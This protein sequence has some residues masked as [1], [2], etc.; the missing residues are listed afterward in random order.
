MTQLEYRKSIRDLRQ[1][2]KGRTYRAG[3]FRHFAIPNKRS[4][5]WYGIWNCLSQNVVAF[6]NVNK[7]V[8]RVRRNSAY[9][10]GLSNIEGWKVVASDTLRRYRDRGQRENTE[11]YA[12]YVTE[13]QLLKF[14][15]A[16]TGDELEIDFGARAS[17]RADIATRLMSHVPHPSDREA[18]RTMYNLPGR[19]FILRANTGQFTSQS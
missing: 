7:K 15:T 17:S 5:E 12:F 9:L 19:R 18:I 2:I 14:L 6:V 10:D 1:I 4:R 11:A 13:P 8:V 3:K 16:A